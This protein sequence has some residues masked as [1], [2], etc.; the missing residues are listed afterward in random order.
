MCVCTSIIYMY[1]TKLTD[2]SL[3]QS[4][5]ESKLHLLPFM[6]PGAESTELGALYLHVRN[7]MV[8]VHTKSEKVEN[9]VH[10]AHEW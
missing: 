2:T 6:L 8:D 4:P 7:V 9:L 3:S 5:L 10:I 1:V